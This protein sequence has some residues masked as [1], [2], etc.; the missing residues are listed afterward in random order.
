MVWARSHY[1]HLLAHSPQRDDD[2]NDDVH[3]MKMIMVIKWWQNEHFWLVPKWGEVL[4]IKKIIKESLRAPPHYVYLLAHSS[5][6][7]HD[8]DFDDVLLW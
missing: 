7:D 2:D 3:L 5:C 6:G 4:T 8:D 1:V